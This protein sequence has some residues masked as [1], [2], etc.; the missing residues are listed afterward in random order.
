[1]EDT[2]LTKNDQLTQELPSIVLNAEAIHSLAETRKWTS[3]FAVLGIIA[4]VFMFVAGIISIIVL[5]M[6]NQESEPTA[7]PAIVTGL[8]Y[9]LLGVIYLF[10]IIY[11]FRFTK[12]VRQAIASSNGNLMSS[13]LYN[14]KLHFRTVGIITI[15]F[16]AVYLIFIMFLLV[17]GAGMLAGNI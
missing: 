10:P 17:F 7:L 13:A 15:G 14:L 5:P 9:L 16:I 2:L 8:V 4:L 3:F 1:M 6:L 12:L 11:L